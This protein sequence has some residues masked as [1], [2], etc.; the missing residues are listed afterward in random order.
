MSVTT[1]TTR[2][3][4]VL[5]SRRDAMRVCAY[6]I[7][8][9]ILCAGLAATAMLIGAP[10]PVVPLVAGACVV[11]PILATWRLSDAVRVL[12]FSVRRVDPAAM[13]EM[14]RELA[15]LPETEHPH[16]F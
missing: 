14:R 12:Q 11:L 10:A 16:G 8:T 5:H 7:V 9:V 1:T 2:K 13:R 6:A 15:A 3:P 4:I